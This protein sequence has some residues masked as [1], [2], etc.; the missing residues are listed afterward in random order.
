MTAHHYGYKRWGKIINS[1]YEYEYIWLLWEPVEN[2][3]KI[4]SR[5]GDILV[6]RLITY[7]TVN[8]LFYT[9][10]ERNLKHNWRDV[11][12][13]AVTAVQHVLEGKNWSSK[14]SWL[15]FWMFY[16]SLIFR[17]HRVWTFSLYSRS[18]IA[19]GSLLSLPSAVSS[20]PSSLCNRFLFIHPVHCGDN[21]S[22]IIIKKTSWTLKVL[23]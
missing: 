10:E 21:E 12:L 5:K 1:S 17:K 4:P 3:G 2:A 8:N 13:L 15:L 6:W 7:G 9:K 14:G 19:L 23:N 20:R 18:L 22:A 16:G 11:M